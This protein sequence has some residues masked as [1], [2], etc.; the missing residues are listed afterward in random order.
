MRDKGKN[1][2]HHMHQPI[3]L[4]TFLFS[5]S[6]PIT[7][8]CDF[9]SHFVCKF[10]GLVNPRIPEN[11]LK[12]MDKILIYSVKQFVDYVELDCSNSLFNLVIYSLKLLV[13]NLNFSY[14]Y[15][16]TNN[17]LS[18]NVNGMSIKILKYVLF[19]L[20]MSRVF[21]V[22]DQNRKMKRKK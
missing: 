6:H 3:M 13:Q 14:K 16:W 11:I 5:E 15:P 8:T 2:G 9:V 4:K 7:W 10:C 17:F 12:N 22:A 21:N 19:L 1:N 18:K 20:K